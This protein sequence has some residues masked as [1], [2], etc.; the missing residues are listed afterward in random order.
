MHV[1]S[2]Q[3]LGVNLKCALVGKLIVLLYFN[4]AMDWFVL[5]GIG[6][7]ITS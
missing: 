6:F 2:N 3:G 5:L 1:L 7:L 4:L